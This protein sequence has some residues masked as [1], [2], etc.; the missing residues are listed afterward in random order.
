[1]KHIGYHEVEN[2]AA[3]KARLIFNISIRERKKILKS[4]FLQL[5]SR[6]KCNSGKPLAFLPFMFP[7]FHLT[8]V[9]SYPFPHGIVNYMFSLFKWKAFPAKSCENWTVTYKDSEWSSGTKLYMI[10]VH[11][12]FHST[13]IFHQE[14]YPVH[15]V[16]K[17]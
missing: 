9:T 15:G 10:L 4:Y 17:S 7:F 2:M 5:L 8:H 12:Y 3:Q 1:M 14:K 16:I 11:Q 13:L 6:Y